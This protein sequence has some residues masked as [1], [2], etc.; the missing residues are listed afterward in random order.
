MS[1]KPDNLQQLLLLE[2]Q[3]LDDSA[4]RL[5]K[6]IT[7]IEQEND[8]DSVLKDRLNIMRA[9]LS[10]FG[11][12][13]YISQFTDQSCD[14]QA[15]LHIRELSDSQMI[16]D[17]HTIISDGIQ[18]QQQI[19][20]DDFQQQCDLNI[21]NVKQQS[22][23][24]DQQAHDSICEEFENMI[25]DLSQ[26]Q[27]QKSQKQEVMKKLSAQQQEVKVYLDIS[28]QNDSINIFQAE[29]L[30]ILESSPKITSQLKTQITSLKIDIEEIKDYLQLPQYQQDSQDNIL[31]ISSLLCDAN[32]DVQQQ[33]QSE[34]LI[35]QE[36]QLELQINEAKLSQQQKI[37]LLKQT[38]QRL[39]YFLQEFQEFHNI[40]I[41]YQQIQNILKQ[42]NDN[43]R[44]KINTSFLN[45]EVKNDSQIIVSP[46]SFSSPK[47][48]QFSKFQPSQDPTTLFSQ[49]QYTLSLS[50]I[51]QS[52]LN[53]PI[54]L[55]KVIDDYLEN[56]Q[57]NQ[58]YQ[59][60]INQLLKHLQQNKINYQ[61]SKLAKQLSL[62][63]KNENLNYQN[64]LFQLLKQ[65]YL[66]VF[67]Q[68]FIYQKDK[69]QPQQIISHLS[70]NQ[71]FICIDDF[72]KYMQDNQRQ[73]NNIIIKLNKFS[74]E[75]NTENEFKS[76][77]STLT[78]RFSELKFQEFE[79]KIRNL[80]TTKIRNMKKH[81]EF[82]SQIIVLRRIE[83]LTRN[84]ENISTSATDVHN[85]DKNLA[86]QARNIAQKFNIQL[87][88]EAVDS[89]IYQFKEN[90][91]NEI[92]VLL[93]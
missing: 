9:A 47:P 59:S 43:K 54:F 27:L 18:Y 68:D 56:Q 25:Q 32:M 90:S 75:N 14:K 73:L 72:S 63:F 48:M 23:S 34:Y 12:I 86:N 42:I 30:N 22:K 29:N 20:Q 31:Q 3:A 57:F 80:K 60:Q 39:Q 52:K 40:V 45:N 55:T 13:F 79:E 11:S 93:Q 61:F 64:L 46:I 5:L 44:L 26:M 24:V 82:Y 76:L 53:L 85:Q 49:I 65:A 81:D 33:K 38:Q 70:L 84:I 77:T 83:E 69:V 89:N 78:K 50:S 35:C 74:S 17:N 7:S 10:N 15:L 16:S 87:V 71:L 8:Y 36:Q 41:E 92:K 51:N 62:P 66:L 1:M 37:Y 2:N 88:N 91:I 58:S 4:V 19:K 28:E 21:S 67:K 6:I